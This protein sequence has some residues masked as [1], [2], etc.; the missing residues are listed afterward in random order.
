MN[1]KRPLKKMSPQ[2]TTCDVSKKKTTLFRI[3]STTLPVQEGAASLSGHDVATQPD[4]VRQN[5]GVTFQSP[6]LDPKLTVGEN[7]S[8]QG[9]LYGLT[10]ASLKQRSADLLQRLGLQERT[11]DIAETL[12]GGLKRRVEI[13]K[14]LLHEPRILLLDEP[15]TGLD[16]GARHDLWRYLTSLRD[17]AGVTVPWSRR[18]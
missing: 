12:S 4:A 2:W 13:A 6:S 15:S 1:G 9:A 3:L 14:S 18:I 11:R 17:E 7:L 5:I 10:G 16:P 8:Y